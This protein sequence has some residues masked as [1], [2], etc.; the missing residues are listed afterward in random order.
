MASE[1]DRAEELHSTKELVPLIMALVSSEETMREAL[2]DVAS[3]W[4]KVLSDA[5]DGAY[6]ARVVQ[7]YL[8]GEREYD[9]QWLSMSREDLLNEINEEVMD[10]LIYRS[11]IAL[12]FGELKI[13]VEEDDEFE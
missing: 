10:L 11:M 4:A 1:I 9:R 7:K 12:R 13:V 6:R 8:R 2:E 3:F 5:D